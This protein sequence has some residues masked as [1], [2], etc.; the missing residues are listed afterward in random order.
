LVW[1]Y[2]VLAGGAHSGGPRQ[3]LD[4][5]EGMMLRDQWIREAL[6]AVRDRM[7]VWQ[8]PVAVVLLDG[9]EVQVVPEAHLSDVSWGERGR[10]REV[11]EVFDTLGSVDEYLAES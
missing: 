1:M 11:L 6:Q 4:A 8:F 7:D 3:S 9:A 10:D 5:Q 2:Y